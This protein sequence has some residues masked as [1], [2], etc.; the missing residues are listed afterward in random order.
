MIG[1]AS[2]EYPYLLR[3]SLP[4]LPHLAP[5][6]VVGDVYEWD[7]E[8]GGAGWKWLDEF[9]EVPVYVRHDV[10]VAV[11]SAGAQA[12][13]TPISIAMTCQCYFL[14]DPVVLKDMATRLPKNNDW[15]FYVA[16]GDWKAAG[17]KREPA[18]NDDD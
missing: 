8:D 14:N 11:T 5:M 12:S 2:R 4:G 13:D 7:A 18:K 17:G 16:N 6:P 15:Y 3:S 9:E 10:A 1:L